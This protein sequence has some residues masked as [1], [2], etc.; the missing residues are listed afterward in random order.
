MELNCCYYAPGRYF[1]T[2]AMHQFLLKIKEIISKYL[3]NARKV[4]VS[5]DIWTKRGMSFSYLRVTAH[6]IAFNKVHRAALAVRQ[7]NG[8]H[9][10]ENISDTIK[11]V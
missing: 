2:K 1:I 10:A 9:N 6:F 8:P 4:H 5:T 3:R 11:K 7:I